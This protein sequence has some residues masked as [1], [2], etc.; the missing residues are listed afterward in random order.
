[1]KF[2]VK[3]YD[4]DEHNDWYTGKII[5]ILLLP[6]IKKAALRGNINTLIEINY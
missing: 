1:M 4:E 3:G 5:L 6:L 2:I